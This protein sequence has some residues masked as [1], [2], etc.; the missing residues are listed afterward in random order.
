MPLVKSVSATCSQWWI[1]T[2]GR[3]RRKAALF[4]AISNDTSEEQ[5]AKID[6]VS[7]VAD[8]SFH[9]SQSL[10]AHFWT[11]LISFEITFF[12]KKGKQID[13][14]TGPSVNLF[15]ISCGWTN[16]GSRSESNLLS[17]PS[18][19]HYEHKEPRRCEWQ[20]AQ[21]APRCSHPSQSQPQISLRLYN[22]APYL[23]FYYYT[24]FSGRPAELTSNLSF[25]SATF[26]LSLHSH[27]RCRRILFSSRDL[28]NKVL[29]KNIQL[30]SAVPWRE[31]LLPVH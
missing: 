1:S 19:S 27:H 3:V 9:L 18:A 21:Q 16:S 5:F 17:Q 22:A 24:F 15:I 2:S 25:C 10:T 4:N 31:T 12:F 11:R 29:K 30:Q 26:Y 8:A 6:A 14:E 13:R 23:F 20:L 7:S 28:Q